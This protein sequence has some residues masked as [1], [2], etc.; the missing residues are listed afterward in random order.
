MIN[1][2]HG[3]QTLQWQRQ[4]LIKS[5]TIENPGGAE[6]AVLWFTDRSIQIEWV[7]AI[8]KD[9]TNIT[10]TLKHGATLASGTEFVTSGTT[11]T[12]AGSLV[13]SFDSPN[14]P[15]DSYIWLETSAVTGTPTQ[16]NITISYR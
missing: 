10:W 3:N 8:I 13:S 12:T 14:V 11:T 15:Q 7:R 2:A 4:R 1:K 5:V 16:L 9:G 6:N